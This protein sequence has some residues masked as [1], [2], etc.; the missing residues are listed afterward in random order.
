MVDV[1]KGRW[2]DFFIIFMYLYIF[3]NCLVFCLFFFD[4]CLIYNVRLLIVNGE[5]KDWF[6]DFESYK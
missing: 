2:F 1:R 6:W 3:F 5:K 4:F